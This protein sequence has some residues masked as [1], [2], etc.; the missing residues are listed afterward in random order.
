MAFAVILMFMGLCTIA[1]PESI[2]ADEQVGVYFVGEPTYTLTNT[3]IKNDRVIGKTF[4][5]NVTLYNSLDKKSEELTVNLTDRD[6]SLQ[7]DIILGPHE[8]QTVSF[9]W[10]TIYI[11]NQRLAINFYPA[12][13]DAEWTP[14]NS[15]SQAF[16]IKVEDG[17]G[18]TA[19]ST[20]GF[21]FVILTFGILVSISLLKKR[22]KK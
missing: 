17:N 21:E 22:R 7:R 16:T 14:Y 19:T 3:I 10:S 9:T 13:L 2:K 11:K 8:T 18:L 5:I 6:G 4:Q 12:D 20:P 1:F 15:G